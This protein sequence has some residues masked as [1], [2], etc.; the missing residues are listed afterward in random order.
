MASYDTGKDRMVEWI[1]TQ[2]REGATC[3]DVGAC[4]GKW[5][6]LLGGYLKMDACE[7]WEPNAKYLEGK[8]EHVFIEN[9]VN[10]KYDH[11]DLVIF[12]DV[13]EHMPVRDAQRVL[14]YA[15]AHSTDYIVGLPF[16]YYQG[17]IYGNPFERH[18]QPDLTPEIVA[19]RY[20]QLE[21]LLR[22]AHDYAYYHRRLEDDGE[23]I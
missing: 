2:Y 21:E 14:A 16:N 20:P 10:L 6:D 7:V 4:D 19:A 22:A 13:L 15:D 1:R 8:Y 23:Q 11:Y 12:G 17:A 5:A 9:I 18:L 3:L